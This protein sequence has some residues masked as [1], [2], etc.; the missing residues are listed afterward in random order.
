MVQ[1][2]SSSFVFLISQYQDREVGSMWSELQLKIPDL[3]KDITV[4]P[5]LL[6]GDLWGGNIGETKDDPGKV[7]Y[8]LLVADTVTPFRWSSGG[9]AS[10]ILSL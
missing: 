6:H 9:F 10:L 2:T 3:F 4:K 1:Q 8:R 7:F 5:A